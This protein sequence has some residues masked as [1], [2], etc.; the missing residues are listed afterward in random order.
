[1]VADACSKLLGS[2]NDTKVN[3]IQVYTGF[4][5]LFS[6]SR[7]RTFILSELKGWGS[8]QEE[9]MIYPGLVPKQKKKKTKI[10]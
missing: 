10:R 8:T 5:L 6:Q 1:M 9:G 4:S 7:S 2:S 3:R